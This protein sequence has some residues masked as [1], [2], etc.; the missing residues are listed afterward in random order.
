MALVIIG[1]RFRPDHLRPQVPQLLGNAL[2]ESPKLGILYVQRLRLDD[3]NFIRARKASAQDLLQVQPPFGFRVAG[4]DEF[5][6]QSIFQQGT[7]QQDCNDKDRHPYANGDPGP[8]ARGSGYGFGG[9]VHRQD[10]PP[11]AAFPLTQPIISRIQVEQVRG[12]PNPASA[13]PGRMA[14]TFNRRRY[15]NPMEPFGY[16]AFR[17]PRRMVTA[18]KFLTPGPGIE[19]FSPKS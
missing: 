12:I 3:Y 19:Q 6:S 11:N 2:N 16:H 1:Q 7:H 9:K 13:G 4:K 10:G 15:E 5:G 14:R 17:L 8:A 18:N